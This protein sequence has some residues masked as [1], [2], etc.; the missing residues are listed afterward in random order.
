[1]TKLGLWSSLLI[2]AGCSSS[3]TIQNRGPSDSG[4]QGGSA[5]TSSGGSAGGSATGGSAGTNGSGGSAGAAGSGG[6]G[7]SGSAGAA[8]AA[9]TGGTSDG[10]GSGGSAG[11]GGA[12]SP[13]NV[14]VDFTAQGNVRRDKFDQAGVSIVG[15]SD[16]QFSDSSSMQSPTPGLG[17]VGGLYSWS[18]D[19]LEFISITFTPR[20]ATNVRYYVAS[21]S[22]VDHDM[23]FGETTVTG[24]GEGGQSL[25][26]LNLVD[27]GSKNVSGLFGG[28][29]ISRLTIAASGEDGIVLGN[30]SFSACLQ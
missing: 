12:C 27:I 3:T 10:G 7:Q 30:L 23:I 1:M 29:P 11:A 22:D 17:V 25:G 6:S 5:G 24:I 13:T 15:S 20:A 19:G 26:S 21:A 9:G 28:V 18:I 2:V 8:G 4:P 16:L 14:T